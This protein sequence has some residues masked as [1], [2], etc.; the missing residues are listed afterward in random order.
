ML[1]GLALL[2][3]GRI[4]AKWV[5][6]IVRRMLERLRLDATLIPFLASVAYYL[7]LIMVVVAVMAQVGIQTASLL[8]VIGAAGLAIGLAMR[9]TLSMPGA[10]QGRLRPSGSSTRR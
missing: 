9:G 2:F 6:R 10:R 8:A 4:A 1:G 7:V 5:R 3:V